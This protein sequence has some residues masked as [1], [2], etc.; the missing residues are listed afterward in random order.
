MKKRKIAILVAIA[1][2]ACISMVPMSLAETVP[3]KYSW[4]KPTT[5]SEPV[6]YVVEM[7]WRSKDS[8]Q[9]TLWGQMGST[10]DLFFAL[11]LEIERC[12]QIRV[13]ARDAAGSFGP[14]SVPSV[15]YCV[16]GGGESGESQDNLG[17]LTPG[18]PGTGG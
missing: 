14:Y 15:E 11:D 12:Y 13:R 10:G 1:A 3:V 6:D 2:L 18:K 9:W 8:D 5:G 17:P 16:P 4:T 7:R